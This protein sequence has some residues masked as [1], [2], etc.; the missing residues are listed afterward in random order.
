MKSARINGGEPGKRW[1]YAVTDGRYPDTVY[2]FTSRAEALD[3]RRSMSGWE[4]DR[5]SFRDR[6]P[7]KHVR[8]ADGWVSRWPA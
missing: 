7:S 2:Y 1:R 8:T 3:W 5:W 6:F 4:G